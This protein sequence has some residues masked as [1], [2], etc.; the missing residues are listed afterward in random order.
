M[1]DM[2][3]WWLLWG[4]G[5]WHPS[6]YRVRRLL[7]RTTS[8]SPSTFKVCGS[9]PINESSLQVILTGQSAMIA[10]VVPSMRYWIS[11]PS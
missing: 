6:T 8:Y 10:Y 9:N 5:W 2:S 4:P 11:P 7:V 3:L 1:N